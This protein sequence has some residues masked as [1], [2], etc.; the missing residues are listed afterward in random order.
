MKL[1]RNEWITLLIPMIVCFSASFACKIKKDA[2]NNVIFRPPAAAFG[3]IWSILFILMGISW[4]IALRSST[5]ESRYNK[6]TLIYCVYGLL[7][8][9]LAMWIICYGCLD[10]EII[11]L[12]TFI[13]SI[14]LTTMCLLIG[15]TLSRLLM[16]PL[17]GWLIFALHLGTASL[18]RT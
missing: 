14:I 17:F 4:V 9:S 13:P 6:K 16:T 2:G 5:V 15:D 11:A 3:I 12:W 7:T 10:K 18:N 1:T 8:I